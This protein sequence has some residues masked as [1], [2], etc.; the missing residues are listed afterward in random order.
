[1]Q[2]GSTRIAVERGDSFHQISNCHSDGLVLVSSSTQGYSVRPLVSF[3]SDK[4]RDKR[5]RQ[6]ALTGIVAI[7]RR[8]SLLDVLLDIV[9][10]SP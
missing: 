7:P 10:S 1:M 6:A 3:G 9:A 2:F 8:R 5:L 4:V